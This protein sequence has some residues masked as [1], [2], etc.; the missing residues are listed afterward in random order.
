ME[1]LIIDAVSPT[2]VSAF[3]N[4]TVARYEAGMTVPAST[5]I[6]AEEHLEPGEG[7]LS[8]V[9]RPGGLSK[10]SAVQC[11][12]L[13]VRQRPTTGTSIHPSLSPTKEKLAVLPP[14]KRSTPGTENQVRPPSRLP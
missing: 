7:T 12:P 2:P 13:V 14:P 10:L 3:R 5:W 11:L 6:D 8:T 9:C 4:S 1:Q